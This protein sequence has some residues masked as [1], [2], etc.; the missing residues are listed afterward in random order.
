[1]RFLTI[2]LVRKH[3]V[4]ILFDLKLD[5]KKLFKNNF[6]QKKKKKIKGL[7]LQRRLS[8]LF[9]K[10]RKSNSLLFKAYKEIDKLSM[11]NVIFDFKSQFFLNLKIKN[12]QSI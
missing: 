5:G 9:E 8:K 12:F 6:F 3:W 7:T 4:L 2:N 11:I 1:M 10:K